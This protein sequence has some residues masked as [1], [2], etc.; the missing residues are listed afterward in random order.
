MTKKN[1]QLFWRQ[2]PKNTSQNEFHKQPVTSA[3]HGLYGSAN[4]LHL[5]S[6]TVK[7]YHIKFPEIKFT[8]DTLARKMW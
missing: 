2:A 8:Y 4:C 1:V 7:C 3:G 6:A 5:S